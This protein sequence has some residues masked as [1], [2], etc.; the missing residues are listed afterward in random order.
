M[1][2]ILADYPLA[3]QLQSCHT[4][5]SITVALEGQ[6]LALGDFQ[7]SDRVM[8]SIESTLLVLIRLS[9][10]ASLGNAIGLVHIGLLRFGSVQFGFSQW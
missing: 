5:E 9:T 6:A 2:L 4:I 10:A 3:V 8:K 7:G 1:G